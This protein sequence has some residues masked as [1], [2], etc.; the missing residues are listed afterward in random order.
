MFIFIALEVQMLEIQIL[1]LHLGI[2]L[3]VKQVYKVTLL[4]LLIVIFFLSFLNKEE[5]EQPK[6]ELIGL[7]HLMPYCQDLHTLTLP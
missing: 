5:M 6:A 3:L 1:E 2:R 4:V 7:K